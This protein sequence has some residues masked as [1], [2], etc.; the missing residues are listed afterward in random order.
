[1]ALW[2]AML[3]VV[4]RAA[5]D[6]ALAL[7]LIA[8]CLLIGFRLLPR[9]V[10]ARARL[11]VPVALSLGLS[12]V[13]LAAWLAGLL[14]GTRAVLP[15]LAV[16]LAVALTSAR[17]CATAC[18]RWARAAWLVLRAD[19]WLA[20]P[21]LLGLA[22]LVPQ[23]LLPVTDSDGI[24]YHLALPKLYLMTGHVGYLPFEY[25]SALPQLPEML[26]LVA[27]E[28]GRPETAKFMHALAFLAALATLA[29]AVHRSR[30]TRSGALFAALAF[31]ATPVAL[32]VAPTAFIDHFAVLH[33]AVALLVAA[34]NGPAALVGIALGGALASKLTVAP[35]AAGLAVAVV[36]R[37]GRR[38][39]LRAAA[40]L[41]IPV[42]AILGPFALHSALA[43]GDPFF[44]VGRTLLGLPVAGASAAT[45][46][47]ATSYH[48]RAPGFLG[49]RWGLAQGASD[50]SELAGWH[51]LLALFALALA[52]ADRRARPFA[53]PVAATLAVGL[54]F[55]PPTRYLLPMFLALAGLAGLA[56]AAA[57]RRFLIRL[58]ALP[59]LASLAT[60]VWFLFTFQR[61]FDLIRG[62]VS[63]DGFLARAV[64]GW[65][66]A[67]L[68]DAQPPGG[69]VMAL[70]FPAPLYFDRPWICEGVMG[71]PPLQE[72]VARARDGGAL[73]RELQAHDVRYL[74]VTPGYGGGTP[75]SLLPLASNRAQLQRVLAL[76]AALARI[77]TAGGV[78]V[79]A[80]PRP[81]GA[82]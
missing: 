56:V 54:G 55:R 43:T 24:R 58:A 31:A 45:L 66:A 16:L 38:R 22:A 21:L 71:T 68:V 47:W 40:G 46:G 14:A 33:C 27:L 8:A 6:G 28:L 44:P 61:P 67:Q 37:R 32:T 63:R 3:E 75:A 13:G 59:V 2:A 51:N 29:A 10:R 79:Y 57:R 39:A 30:A 52:V 11:G 26:D 70:D 19:A 72:W 64:P 60:G 34:G 35:F 48:A 23:L 20:V 62:T 82:R 69:T 18:R 42:I 77:G 9:R 4:A 12:A 53:F 36:V 1:V 76:R 49:I 74:V 15:L 78:D 5:A 25:H 73:L 81:R 41:A 17:A 7:A 65:R 50:V 80:V